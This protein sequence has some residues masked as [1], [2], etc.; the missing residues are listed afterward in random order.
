MCGLVGFAGKSARA[1]DIVT[2]MLILDSTR[3]VDGTGLY[4]TNFKEEEL[5]K[6]CGDCYNLINN[7]KYSAVTSFNNLYIGHNR[8][9]T[10]GKNSS[11]NS[12]PF[13][14]GKI[15][16][17]HNGTLQYF[18]NKGFDV[19]SEYLLDKIARLGAKE[20]VKDE[21]GAWALVWYNK[22]EKTLNF[23]RNKERPLVYA[24]D[25]DKNLYWASEEWMI[26]AVKNKF[27]IEIGNIVPFSEDT[28]YIFT[29]DEEG[30]PSIEDI[31]E[32]VKAEK[33][34][35]YNYPVKTTYTNTTYT[36][37][38]TK[39]IYAPINGIRCSDCGEIKERKEIAYGFESVDRNF[40]KVMN[41]VCKECQAYYDK[42]RGVRK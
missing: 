5:I 9:S 41:Y 33:K 12:H 17:A 18:Y 25:E 32:D 21:E 4:M 35:I 11:M 23:L 19:D 28:Q 22:E 2:F 39:A 7:K 10:K 20:A 31:V 6:S 16:G 8:A 30:K 36:R 40:N 3:G 27:K 37:K 14:V 34:S 29:F 24:L 1:R 15:V 42:Y 38:K 13:D 26:E